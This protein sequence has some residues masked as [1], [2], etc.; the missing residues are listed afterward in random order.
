MSRLFS[1]LLLCLALVSPAFAQS[2]AA[3]GSIEGTVVDSSGGVLPG[4]TVTVTNTDTGAV[5]SLVTNES[6]IF[7]APLLTLGTYTVTAELEGFKKFE[8]VKGFMTKPF[9]TD[10]LLTKVEE[11]IGKAG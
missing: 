9:K 3:N 10:D 4:V 2:Q 5:R 8:Q 1:A 7:R 6:G 11:I